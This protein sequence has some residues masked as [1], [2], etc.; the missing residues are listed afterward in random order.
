MGRPP[1][2]QPAHRTARA[3]R[4]FELLVRAF[5]HDLLR[6]LAEEPA[7]PARHVRAYLRSVCDDALRHPRAG[8]NAARLLLLPAYQQ[9]WLDFVDEAC[10]GDGV[11]GGLSRRCRSAAEGLWLDQVLR[12]SPARQDIALAR[13]HLL[14]LC[15]AARQEAAVPA[16]PSLQPWHS[17]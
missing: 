10:A 13:D 2:T 11:N 4:A 16:A 14:S 15:A 8:R 5:R 17:P 6:A 9:V 1:H 7:G 3:D 12:Q